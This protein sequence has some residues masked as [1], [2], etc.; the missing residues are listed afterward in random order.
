MKNPSL[1]DKMPRVRGRF[2]ENV[3]LSKYTWF[4][5]GGVAEI[6]FWPRDEQDLSEF[7]ANISRDIPKR[8]INLPSFHDITESQLLKICRILE[9]KVQE[10][11]A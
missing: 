11:E 5:V 10:I 6:L 4:R 1:M 8:A 3:Q 2:M 9:N 7:F